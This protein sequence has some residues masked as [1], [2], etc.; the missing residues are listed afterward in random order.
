MTNLYKG[1]TSVVKLVYHVPTLTYVGIKFMRNANKYASTI[2]SEVSIMKPL[3]HPNTKRF[4]WSRGEK[5][6]TQ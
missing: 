4:T 1:N 2:S 5:P 6:P 3:T